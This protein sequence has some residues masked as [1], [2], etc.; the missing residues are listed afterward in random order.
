M[1]VPYVQ[2]VVE[3][4]NKRSIATATVPKPAYKTRTPDEWIV[5]HDSRGRV[6]VRAF[7][8][9]DGMT[10]IGTGRWEN[11]CI[12]DRVGITEQLPSAEQWTM[13]ENLLYPPIRRSPHDSAAID[14]GVVH[15]PGE[16]PA[17][18]PPDEIKNPILR[19]LAYLVTVIA[20][21]GGAVGYYYWRKLNGGTVAN[22][23]KCSFDSDCKSGRCDKGFSSRKTCV[24]TGVRGDRCKR[25]RDCSSGACKLQLC[26]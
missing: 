21:A 3:H 1:S 18:S 16:A 26:D 14:T 17:S 8:P 9:P 25:D 20:L 12:V 4:G 7:A 19:W 6:V 10:V 22:G 5:V 23:E 11:D 13:L 15:R 2:L 24:E